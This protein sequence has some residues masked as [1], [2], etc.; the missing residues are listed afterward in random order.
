MPFPNT[1]SPR[2]R[3]WR[4]SFTWSTRVWF[5][6]TASS[7]A[8]AST[9]AT[10]PGVRSSQRE[11]KGKTMHIDPS[12]NATVSRV[13]CMEAQLNPRRVYISG[14]QVEIWENPVL[15]FRCTQEEINGYAEHENW[16]LL[17]NA[18]VLSSV[19]QQ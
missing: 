15:P 5:D 7:A 2:R 14:E 3:S 13:G 16:V 12:E 4:P 8:P 11:R 18:L 17:F 1:P 19:P 6:S 9:S 10:F